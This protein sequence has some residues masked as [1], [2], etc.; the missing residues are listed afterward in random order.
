MLRP[1]TLLLDREARNFG[2]RLIALQCYEITD[3]LLQLLGNHGLSG[4]GEEF[5]NQDTR[6]K[7][8]KAVDEIKQLMRQNKVQWELLRNNCMAHRDDDA[9]GQLSIIEGLN[10][11]ALQDAGLQL[12]KILFNLLVCLALESKAWNIQTKEYENLPNEFQKLLP[13]LNE[14]IANWQKGG[15]Q[16]ST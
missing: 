8:K 16:P 12:T 3:K 11:E 10:A 9:F 6:G 14:M 1:G 2:G 7:V 13:R 15:N 5:S 4:T